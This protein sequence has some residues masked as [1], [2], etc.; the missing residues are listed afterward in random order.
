MWIG[1]QRSDPPTGCLG[2]PG[3]YRKGE[4]HGGIFKRL[5][6]QQRRPGGH[7]RAQWA[8]KA[9]GDHLEC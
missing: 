3:T 7:E 9:S 5:V 1:L 6:K 8:P 4:R 2:G